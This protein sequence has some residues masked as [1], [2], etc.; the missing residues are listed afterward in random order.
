MVG[1]ARLIFSSPFETVVNNKVDTYSQRGA[2]VSCGC[3]VES[4]RHSDERIKSRM[5]G[6]GFVVAS[7]YEACATDKY[8]S[9]YVMHMYKCEHMLPTVLHLSSLSVNVTTIHSPFCWLQFPK[10]HAKT[11][12]NCDPVWIVHA[13]TIPSSNEILVTTDN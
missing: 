13:F 2:F 6:T 1:D 7:F 9:Y 3:R 5:K 11:D 4:M 12:H 8:L 10:W